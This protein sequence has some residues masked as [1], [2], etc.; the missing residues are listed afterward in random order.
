MAKIKYTKAKCEQFLNF[1]SPKK[2]DPRWIINGTKCF[3]QDVNKPQ[4]G[5]ALREYDP[6]SFETFYKEWRRA[7]I[8][9]DKK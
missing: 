6:D 3:A 2:G 4:Y 1:N 8:F 7:M 5:R 9:K